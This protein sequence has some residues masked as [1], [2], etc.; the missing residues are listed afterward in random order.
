MKI[1]DL[2]SDTVT[3]PTPKMLEAMFKAKLGDDV[4][5][6]DPTVKAL[7]KKTAALFGAE[8]GIFCPSGTMTN[9]I[10][11]KLHTQPMSEVICDK[12]SHIFNY[13]SGGIAFNSLA[14]VRTLNGNRGRFTAEELLEN[15]HP[16][17]IHHPISS[18]VC[19]ENTTNKGGGAYWDFEEIKKIKKICIKNKLKFHLDGARIFNAL[20]ETKINTKE[21]G[22]IFDTISICFSKGL[23][24]PVGSV[25]IGK[26]TDIE[27]SKRIRKVLGG[28]MRQAGILAAAGIY[29]LDNN[30][31]RLKTDH[32]RAKKLA[33]TIGKLPFVT[34]LIPVDTNILVFN[35]D[36][37]Y[38]K[39]HFIEKLNKNNIKVAGFGKQTIRMVTH[40]DID[41]KMIEN[42]IG[43]LKK[44]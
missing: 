8:A 32:E 29:A 19:I 26:K 1:I 7:E 39:D 23:G 25:L 31:E 37:S 14:S 44:M 5:E 38:S 2:R 6:E 13:E 16:D 27:R 12:L 35:L 20:I 15:I 22:E 34:E 42:V 33:H 24:A 43:V 9:Q 28:G 30:I 11:I 36:E 17:N 18:L 40:L 41:D 10:A 4:L 3:K 21:F